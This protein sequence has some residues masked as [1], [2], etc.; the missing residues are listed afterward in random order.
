MKPMQKHV[1]SKKCIEAKKTK[2]L[3][4]IKASIPVMQA[5]GFANNVREVRLN[6]DQVEESEERKSRINLLY[7]SLLK[8]SAMKTKVSKNI[9]FTAEQKRIME[10]CFDAEE[11]DKK[12]RYTAQSCEKLMK[13]QLGNEMTLTQ[14]QIKSYWGAYKRRK[15]TNN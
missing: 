10:R 14:R 15:S 13:E 5:L 2:T 7:C 11:T 1:N 12:N 9:R 8:G 4:E 3:E 6:S